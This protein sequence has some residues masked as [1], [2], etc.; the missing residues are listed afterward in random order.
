MT[1]TAALAILAGLVLLAV[2]VH[3]AWA[4]RRGRAP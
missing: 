4:T 1:L 2:V 3:G